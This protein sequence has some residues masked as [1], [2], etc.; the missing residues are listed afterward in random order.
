[1]KMKSVTTVGVAVLLGLSLTCGA[2]AAV[3]GS[4]KAITDPIEACIARIGEQADYDGAKRIVHRV[5]SIDQKNL[6]ELSIR[7]ETLVL[8]DDESGSS[9]EYLASC[10]TG[11][12]GKIVKFRLDDRTES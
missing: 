6:I 3:E 2:S 10:V 4:N 7:I 12:L 9:R 8:L 11:G 5:A 1:M